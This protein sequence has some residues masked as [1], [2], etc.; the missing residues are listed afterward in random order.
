MPRSKYVPIIIVGL[1]VIGFVVSVIGT[2]LLTDWLKYDHYDK[3]DFIDSDTYQA[4]FLTNDQIYFG[5]LKNISSD[6]LILF[7]VYY[8]K[9]NESIK[10]YPSSAVTRYCFNG[11][12]TI[13]RS[14]PNQCYNCHFHRG[15][16]RCA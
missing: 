14:K 11:R 10:N 13:G 1:V 3:S 5:R 16:N 2:P 6:Y 12:T 9:I 7:D 4:V 8:V 15:Y